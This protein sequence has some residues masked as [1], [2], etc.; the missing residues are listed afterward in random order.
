MWQSIQADINVMQK[1]A[2]K[3][4]KYRSLCIEIQRMWNMTCVI[5]PVITGET[6]VVTVGLKEDL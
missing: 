6:A 1:A 4:L 5:I 2:E 3:E